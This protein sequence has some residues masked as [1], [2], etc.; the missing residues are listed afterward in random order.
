M[1]LAAPCSHG[2]TSQPLTPSDRVDLRFENQPGESLR[3]LPC[4]QVEW[5]YPGALR[6]IVAE[7]LAAP[8]LRLGGT[9]PSEL[10]SCSAP[11][12]GGYL[13]GRDSENRPSALEAP[14]A[15]R[16]RAG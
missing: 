10:L 4:S 5:P 8:G 2:W 15:V 13:A 6:Q 9:A 3:A 12:I 11:P 7:D 14:R 16:V 1:S